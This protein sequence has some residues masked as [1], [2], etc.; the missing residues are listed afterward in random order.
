MQLLCLICA[1]NAL[2]IYLNKI[3]LLM[4]EYLDN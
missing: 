3:T 4:P 2:F 1:I